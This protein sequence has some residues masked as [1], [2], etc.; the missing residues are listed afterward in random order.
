MFPDLVT[1]IFA[2]T[3]IALYFVMVTYGIELFLYRKTRLWLYIAPVVAMVLSFFYF[4]YASPDVSLRIVI[5]ST[6]AFLFSVMGAYRVHMDSP[7][8]INGRNNLVVLSLV[9]QAGYLLFRTV[10]TLLLE[11]GIQDFMSSSSVQAFTFMMLIGCNV[12]I[13]LSLIIF[14]SQKVELELLEA[15][16]E[17]KTLEGILPLCMHCKQ[18]RDDQG[19]WNQLE[20]YISQHT[21]AQ[22]SHSICETCLKEHYPEF[23]DDVLS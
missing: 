3:C 18:I 15:I 10:Y 21:A 20:A 17:I 13:F 7:Q 19:Y 2:N 12:S 1:I 16:K 6:L 23:E 11:M 5:I 22:F 14:N 8:I 9:V 4:T